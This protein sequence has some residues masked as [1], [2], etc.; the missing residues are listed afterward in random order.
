MTSEEI[1]EHHADFFL[2]LAQRANLNEEA[3]GV[4]LHS[5]V[6]PEHNNIRAALEWATAMKRG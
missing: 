3:D 2:E 6:I 5:L 4:M 1:G